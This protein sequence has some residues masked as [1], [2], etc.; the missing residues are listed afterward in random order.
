MWFVLLYFHPAT[1]QESLQPNKTVIIRIDSLFKYYGVI[2]DSST[3]VPIIIEAFKDRFNPNI[4]E[5]VNAEMIFL[6]SYNET[7]Q[8]TAARSNAKF[9]KDVKKEFK[10]Y[11]RQYVGYIDIHGNPNIITQ[12]F[13][14][15]KKRIV[16]REIGDSWKRRF[17][18]MFSEHPS[19]TTLTYRVNL[20][21]KKLYA[22]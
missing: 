21:E 16:N 22:F 5:I 4:N 19:F 20:K 15:S 17:I 9:I 18:I 6:Q 2:I 7:N 14:Y 3:D 12:L 13:D 11:N 8:A 10:K 1:C